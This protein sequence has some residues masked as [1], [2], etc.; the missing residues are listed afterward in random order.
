MAPIRLELTA[1]L[2]R[3]LGLFDLPGQLDWVGAAVASTEM[4][5]QV[6]TPAYVAAVQSASADP[7]GWSAPSNAAAQQ[8]HGLGSDDVPAFAG[9][10]AAAARVVQG[11]TD[12]AAAVWRGEIEHGVNFCGGL[13]HAQADQASGFCVYNDIAVAISWLLDQGAQRV[14]YVDV[15]V[16]HGDG[17]EQIFWNDPRV[18][19]ISVHESGQALFP[20]T[21]F[22][23]EVGG[24]DAQGRAIN[25]PL[26]AGT[27]DSGWLRACRELIPALLRGFGPEIL[28]TQHG[29]DTHSLDPLAHFAVSIEAQVEMQKLLHELS[30]ELCSGRWLATGGGGYDV[31]DVVPRSWAHLVAVAAHRPIALH[32]P[33]PA[34]WTAAVQALVGRPGPRLMGD[35]V[36]RAEPSAQINAE[37]TAAIAKTQA[38]V[39]RFYPSVED[40]AVGAGRGAGLDQVG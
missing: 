8:R 11:T 37:I 13:H 18:L 22:A 4:L 12:L 36:Q 21:G 25:L 16:H 30:H 2:C 3:A 27:S 40:P 20:G 17:V 29:C 14:A 1:R 35:A 10:H 34:G 19:T 39:A 26:P 33:V 6:H 32:E 38:Q 23:E 5:T 7:Y 15:D 28:I 9:M 24:P 31:V